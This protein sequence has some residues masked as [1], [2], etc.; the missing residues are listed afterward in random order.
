MGAAA[1]TMICMWSK[2]RIAFAETTAY[3]IAHPSV[4][5]ETCFYDH[6]H[7]THPRCHAVLL[8]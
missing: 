7:V 6:R 8:V 4:T 1:V 2:A 3:Y 5:T